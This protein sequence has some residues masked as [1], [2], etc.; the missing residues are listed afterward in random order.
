MDRAFTN[1]LSQNVDAAATFYQKLLGMERHFNSDWFVIL[2]HPNKAGFEFGILANDHEI[3]PPNLRQKPGGSMLTFV[4]A[5]VDQVYLKAK[6]LGAEILQMPT[7]MPYGQ[8]RLLLSDTD[9]TTLDI[10]APVAVVL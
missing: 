9:G 5:D 6:Q 4:V 7:D 1:V 2:T 10:S 3:V 8:R